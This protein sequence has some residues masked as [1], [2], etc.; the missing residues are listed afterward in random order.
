[1]DSESRTSGR[2]M[3][4]KCLFMLMILVFSSKIERLA[5]RCEGEIPARGRWFVACA[6][7]GLPWA[8]SGCG[9]P[10]RCRPA[11]SAAASARWRDE[12]GWALAAF[13]L[14]R[15]AGAVRR[16]GPARAKKMARTL[17]CG[18]VS[19]APVHAGGD[20]SVVCRSRATRAGWAWASARR[21]VG[22]DAIVGSRRA[23]CSACLLDKRYLI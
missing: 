7:T 16:P 3:L 2:R 12:K 6:A 5:R 22:M 11:C 9:R 18:P 13:T 23:C 14:A 21:R 8:G 1:M 17:R 20:S 10:G 15:G 19:S 4:C